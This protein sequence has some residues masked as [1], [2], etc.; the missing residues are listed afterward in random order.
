MEYCGF[1]WVHKVLPKPPEPALHV[2]EKK[3]KTP[4]GLWCPMKKGNSG[5]FMFFVCSFI[6]NR[7]VTGRIGLKPPGRAPRAGETGAGTGQANGAITLFFTR[8]QEFRAL[9]DGY[10]R[11]R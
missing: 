7:R 1:T 11:R 4:Q 5:T 10:A 2:A 9:S 8:L 6:G 3:L